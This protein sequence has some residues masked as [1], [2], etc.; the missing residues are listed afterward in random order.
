MIK[1][2]DSLFN[3]LQSD[4]EDQMNLYLF[5]VISKKYITF[6]ESVF[7]ISDLV[8]EKALIE[9]IIKNIFMIAEKNI[10]LGILDYEF[11]KVP[12]ILS[13]LLMSSQLNN[14]GLDNYVLVQIDK[15]YKNF[16]SNSP[17]SKTFF[18]TVFITNLD[19]FESNKLISSI[20]DGLS[21]EILKTFSL[22]SLTDINSSEIQFQNDLSQLSK[23]LGIKSR[24][25]V[26]KLINQS[27]ICFFNTQLS[28]IL[29]KRSQNWPNPR[30][31]LNL[32]NKKYLYNKSSNKIY[33]GIHPYFSSILQ[34][35][36]HQCNTF[37]LNIKNF[38]DLVKLNKNLL[39]NLHFWKVN[40]LVSDLENLEE[41]FKTIK[42]IKRIKETSLTNNDMIG[43]NEYLQYHLILL[44]YLI[45]QNINRS[46]EKFIQ[47]IC[48]S[49][50]QVSNKNQN[51]SFL[52]NYFDLIVKT[53][54][55]IKLEFTYN[56]NIHERTYYRS[57]LNFIDRCLIVVLNQFDNMSYNKKVSFMKMIVWASFM[58]KRGRLLQK[59]ENY[60]MKD[61][62]SFTEKTLLIFWYEKNQFMKS[63]DLEKFI[64]YLKFHN[65]LFTSNKYLL[66]LD[67][68][69]VFASNIFLTLQNHNYLE[70][71][72]FLSSKNL[73]VY[74]LLHKILASILK[75][76]I[77]YVL[78]IVENKS[79]SNTPIESFNSICKMFMLYNICIN[80]NTRL[81][82]YN[83]YLVK[84][85]ENNENDD[86]PLNNFI[87]G[88]V[89]DD[90]IKQVNKEVNLNK[91]NYLEIEKE[92]N[93]FKQYS[94]FTNKLSKKK[95]FFFDSA[96]TITPKQK[97][98]IKEFFSLK[99]PKKNQKNLNLNKENEEIAKDDHL[100]AN[101]YFNEHNPQIHFKLEDVLSQQK[102]L[103]DYIKS[104]NNE[105]DIFDSFKENS[106]YEILEILKKWLQDPSISIDKKAVIVS[107]SFQI[108]SK[109]SYTI[110]ENVILGEFNKILKNILNLS[111]ADLTP[112]TQFIYSICSNKV[113]N[114]YVAGL[115]YSITE[116]L[117][118]MNISVFGFS[119]K[120]LLMKCLL[121]LSP[122]YSFVK[123]LL[124]CLHKDFLKV[125]EQEKN[126]I[127][128]EKSL[129]NYSQI[130]TFCNYFYEENLFENQLEDYIMICES[131]LK[132]VWHPLNHSNDRD[133]QD[134]MLVNQRIRLKNF[135]IEKLEKD[136]F[137]REN[138]KECESI[139]GLNVDF[140]LLENIVID[141]IPETNKI[142]NEE[143]S[144]EIGFKGVIL[145]SKGYIYVPLFAKQLY[146]L[147]NNQL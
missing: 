40:C 37:H 109:E 47:E 135:F 46:N 81:E 124:V 64:L 50:V 59:I 85:L 91:I 33:F 25:G 55:V 4:L 34:A 43:N 14:L 9:N 5:G 66:N 70:M 145:E 93:I 114:S 76:N 84:Y 105:V 113:S 83:S 17:I 130:L 67:T 53:L 102:N 126:L 54:H 8:K 71:R 146:V 137:V 32:F 103:S 107:Y 89:K 75:C 12:G 115:I 133:V 29:L 95:K 140:V 6:L 99:T 147:S 122:K 106:E 74:M 119:S 78:D 143:F 10:E 15:L 60:F 13:G 111:P 127:L 58:N 132:K 30:I 63:V 44:T 52:V 90:K 19:N 3:H 128:F 7:K 120:L 28:S 96:N 101:F 73:I 118:S 116:V 94:F 125:M 79:P 117:M 134:I 61:L 123:E 21:L 100:E 49:F 65:N 97:Q 23:I 144:N 68:L 86:D 138:L 39:N 22:K 104:R 141:I 45:D 139:S 88:N 77:G 57:L 80:R 108:F 131:E 31:L 98:K 72:D 42:E 136:S 62:S 112:L 27:I 35:L 82:E 110:F 121:M 24:L 11:E 18:Y 20:I 1:L 26:L 2:F 56:N 48:D 36:L 129:L 38:E 92:A 41:V 51:V 142:L 87:I 16:F 69:N